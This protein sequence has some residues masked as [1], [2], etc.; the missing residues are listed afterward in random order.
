MKGSASPAEENAEPVARR[1]AWRTVP[2]LVCGIPATAV[3]ALVLAVLPERWRRREVTDAVL[4]TWSRFCL[5][6]TGTRVR[7]EGRENL[8]SDAA[9][10]VVANHR[11]NLDPMV[12]LV[13]FGSSLRVLAKRELFA[14]PLLGRAL[15]AAG[16]IEVDRGH[17][18]RAAINQAASRA[19]DQGVSLLVF[20]EGTFSRESG[21]RPFKPGAFVIAVDNGADVLPVSVE[22]TGRVW[23]ADRL[24]IFGG[25]VRVRIGEPLPTAGLERRDVA[26]L[27]RRAQERVA[28]L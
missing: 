3:G 17:A 19:L 4:G 24:R 26:A 16:M 20:P 28:A 14:V 10:V 18:D 13:V 2:A 6:V 11:S 7:V 22:G 12:L 8:D 25:T 21:M 15:R 5:L 1:F 9:R 27:A 23:P